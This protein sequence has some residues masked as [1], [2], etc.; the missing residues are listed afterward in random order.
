MSPVQR[1]FAMDGVP[2]VDMLRYYYR[3]AV[4]GIGLMITEPVAVPD[5]AAAVDAGMAG[6]HGGAALR[7]WR[8]ICRL[9]H[10]SP[11]RI[12]SL[13]SHA[14]MLC[15]VEGDLV[16][17]GPSGQ[18]LIPGGRQGERMNAGRIDTVVQ[19]FGRA[20]AAARVLGFDAVAI[21]GADAHLIEQFLRPESNHRHDEYGG[22]I[23]SR[24]RFAC[25]VLHAVRKAVGRDFPVLFRFS[26]YTSLFGRSPLVKTPAELESLVQPLCDAGVDMFCCADKQASA[27]AFGGSPLNLA[28]WTRL[29]TGRPTI[30]EGAVGLPGVEIHPLVRRMRAGEYDLISVGRALLADAEWGTK[31][32]LSREEEIIPFTKRAWLHLF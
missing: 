25:R 23:R 32:H 26:Q 21:N 1:F 22:D 8:R 28:G 10:T 27:P 7:A 6:F 31:I 11:C 19:A 3:R 4:Q 14:G 17:I 29:L 13:L 24:A 9:V 30:T 12:A 20:A 5:P 15:Q 16:P 2:T 18:A